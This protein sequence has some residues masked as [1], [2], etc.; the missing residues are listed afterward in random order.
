MCGRS[1]CLTSTVAGLLI[2]CCGFARGTVA[3]EPA[4][5]PVEDVVHMRSLRFLKVFSPDGKWLAYMVQR[6]QQSRP[7]DDFDF[8]RTGVPVLGV[9]CDIYVTN[10][11]TR[12]TRNLTVGNGDNASPQW[13]PDGRYLAFISSRDHT[14]QAGLWVWDSHENVLRRVCKASLRMSEQAPEWT[15]DSRNV[16]VETLPDGMSPDEYVERV[17]FGDDVIQKPSTDTSPAFRLYESTGDPKKAADGWGLNW[18]LRDLQL[19]ELESGQMTL[20]VHGQR[21]SIFQ[22]SEDGTRVAYSVPKRFET[23]GSQQLLYDIVV[24][25]IASNRDV[26]VAPEVRLGELGKFSLSPDGSQVAFRTQ[27]PEETIHDIYTVSSDGGQLRNLTNLP[28]RERHS[29]KSHIPPGALR[30]GSPLWDRDGKYIYYLTDGTLHRTSLDRGGEEIVADID[31]RSITQLIAQPSN[32]LFIEEKNDS[33]VVITHDGEKKQDGFYRINLKSG[34]AS[35]LI[36]KGECYTCTSSY[37]LQFATVPAEAHLLAYIAQNAQHS[38]DIWLATGEFTSSSQLSNI[39]PQFDKYAMGSSRLIEW[40]DGDG[41]QLQGA[42]LLPSNYKEGVPIPLVVVVYGGSFQSDHLNR[43]GGSPGWLMPYYNV[44][45]FA[46]RGYAVLMPD[47]PQNLGTPLFDLA[48]TVLPGINKCI[49]LGIADA[50]RIGVIGQSY[51]GY[52]TL[53]LLVQTQRF[54][55]AVASAGFGD[56]VGLYGEMSVDG[57]VFGTALTE[58]GQALMGGT[59]W[60]YRDRYIENSP[61]FYLDRI[62]TPLLIFHGA[63]DTGVDPFLANEIFVGLRRLGRTVQYVQ[64]QGEGHTVTSLGNQ[65]D[66]ARRIIMWLDKYL[67]LTERSRGTI[68]EPVGD[69]N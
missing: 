30:T 39:N 23:P 25:T 66:A 6:V 26:V 67:S 47:A 58:K 42:L 46:T 50:N 36:E 55:A 69:K 16:I 3:Q 68:V 35:K 8:S 62:Q 40:R 11:Q 63:E 13:S 20:I 43:F 61:I 51:G 31:G 59:P 7:A 54:K 34:A 29:R 15:P 33:T 12:E 60:E 1:L 18:S 52:S 2:S 14:G 27:G 64:Y 24:H 48:K 22:L 21:I 49:E 53:A 10:T 45:L 57:T 19:T 32:R 65:E 56:L 44:Q 28:P 4:P 9:E 37:Q 41:R 38:P 5:L 17:K